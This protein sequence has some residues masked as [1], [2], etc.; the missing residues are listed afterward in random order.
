MFSRKPHFELFSTL[1]DARI[2]DLK[3]AHE[4]EVKQLMR[5]VDALAEQVEYL[6]GQL[7]RPNL[8]KVPSLNPTEQPEFLATS[9]AFLSEEEEELRHLRKEGLISDLDLEQAL[10]VAGLRGTQ[11]QID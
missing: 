5:L 7:G 9:N 11:I 4:R 2:A 10:A 6:R 8:S 3:E 1:A